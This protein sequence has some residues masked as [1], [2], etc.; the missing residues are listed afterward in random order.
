MNIA[1]IL[2]ETKLQNFDFKPSKECI[3]IGFFTLEE[4]KKLETYPNIQVFLSQYNPANH[5]HL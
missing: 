1:N 3:E 5:V 4:A 2:Y